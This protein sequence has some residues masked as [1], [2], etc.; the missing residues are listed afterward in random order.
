[1]R[2]FPEAA[3]HLLSHTAGFDEI[4]PGTQAPDQ[5]SVLPLPDFLD[6]RLVRL[7]PPGR[8][9]MDS[10]YGTT[11][12]GALV[13]DVSGL[14]FE[15]YLARNLWS[16]LGMRRTCI[17]IPLELAGDVATGYEFVDGRHEAQ[18]WEWYHTTP[19][20]SINSTAADMASW[21]IAHL[22]EGGRLTT[23]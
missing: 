21:M 12:A 15:N 5:A 16:P 4:R 9:P 19:A 20:S 17:T 8:V 2:A 1:M 11:L 3:D 18:A 13:E 23:R 14:P 10:T 7:W 6:S 22:H